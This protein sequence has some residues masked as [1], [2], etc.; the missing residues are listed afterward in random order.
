[1]DQ[2]NYEKKDLEQGAYF[3]TDYADNKIA[4]IFPNN[5]QEPIEQGENAKLVTRD[6]G[7]D[8]WK[9]RG[10]Y[11]FDRAKEMGGRHVKKY[12]HDLADKMIEE[13]R[14]QGGRDDFER[15]R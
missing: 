6:F 10:V 8:E 1:M 13:A 4:V 7:K 14:S 9:Q 2:W 5:P 15:G 12:A 3:R 11:R